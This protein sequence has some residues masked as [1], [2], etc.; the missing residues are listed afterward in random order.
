VLKRLRETPEERLSRLELTEHFVKQKGHSSSNLLRTIRGLERVH[1]VHLRDCS[2]L[3]K[4]YVSLPQPGN[5]LSDEALSE[6]LQ[7]IGGRS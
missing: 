3:A 7:E 6:I 5:F 4:A 1:L 2:D